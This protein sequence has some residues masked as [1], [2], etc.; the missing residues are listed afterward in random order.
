MKKNLILVGMMGVG[1]STLGKIVA[2]RLKFKF[3]DTDKLIEKKLKMKIKDIFDKKGENF[4]R[5]EEE[6]ITLECL[7]EE[8]SV[9]ALGGGGF[10]NEKIRNKILS[11]SISVWLDVSIKTLSSR[12]KN[13]PKR[14]L[15]N[16][17]NNFKIIEKLYNKRRSIY[18]LSDH[19]VDCNNQSLKDISN[20]ILEIYE[21]N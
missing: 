13:S 21:N 4:F 20:E 2:K 16:Y 14:P 11:T 12:L 15:I 18:N 6:K 8:K 19:K 5:L 1:K 3:K 10:V 9:I 7:R 17:K